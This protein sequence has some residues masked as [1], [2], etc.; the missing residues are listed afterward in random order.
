[1]RNPDRGSIWLLLNPFRV[2]DNKI[3]S[4]PEGL[5]IVNPFRIL[6]K[7]VSRQNPTMIILKLISDH[8]K[9]HQ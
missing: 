1:M 9:T 6:G 4:Y 2:P 3:D 5:F 8:L 7:Q